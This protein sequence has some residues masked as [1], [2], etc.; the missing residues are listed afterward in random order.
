M[1]RFSALLFVFALIA[2]ACGGGGDAVTADAGDD[3]TVAVGE[4]PQ[5]DG[6][7]STG[8]ITNYE[9][10]IIEAPVA[11]DADKPLRE[12]D[13]NCG[14]VLEAA[15]V[16]DDVGEWIIELRVTDGDSTA[17]DQVTVTVTG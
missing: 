4:N 15:M 1:K 11:E 8:D 17:T 2:T 6:C 10:H 7:S 16:I 3:F 5:F 14:F 12:I 9:W 13:P